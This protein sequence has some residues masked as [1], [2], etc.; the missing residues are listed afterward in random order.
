VEL[1]VFDVSEIRNVVEITA[2][3]QALDQ[4]SE[5]ELSLAFEHVNVCAHVFERGLE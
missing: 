3:L 4:T 5:R 1:F 2:I